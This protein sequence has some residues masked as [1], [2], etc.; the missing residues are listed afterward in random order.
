[1]IPL[2]PNDR[3]FIS[4]VAELDRLLKE[5]T[6]RESIT[7]G[8]KIEAGEESQ[9]SQESDAS[10]PVVPLASLFLDF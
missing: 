5:Q 9:K 10:Q 1:M 7:I 2:K 4:S 3:R 8:S 6:S